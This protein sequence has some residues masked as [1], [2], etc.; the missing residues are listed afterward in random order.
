M[1]RWNSQVSSWKCRRGA[2]VISVLT[3][4]LCG[5]SKRR[6]PQCEHGGRRG[7]RTERWAMSGMRRHSQFQRGSLGAK[8]GAVR[9]LWSWGGDRGSRKE[10]KVLAVQRR[11]ATLVR[12][13]GTESR[14]MEICQLGTCENFQH[15][16]VKPKFQVM[17]VSKQWPCEWLK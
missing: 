14:S 3:K 9:K 7:P 2:R 11:A 15:L 17:T 5:S 6:T 10:I 8:S 1:L 4:I 12:V 16:E 13:R